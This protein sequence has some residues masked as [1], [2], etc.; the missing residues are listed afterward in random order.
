MD[1][2]P[3]LG[4]LNDAQREAVTAPV[5]PV[6]VLAGAGS[7]KTRVL[8]HRIAWVIQVEHASPHSVLAVTFTNKAAAEM[9]GRIEKLLGV[10]GSAMW[11]GTFHGIAHR[12]LRLHWR[13]AGLA[14]NFQI[15]DSEDQSRLIKK[16]MKAQELD[17]NRWSPREVQ[18]F[19]NANK[20]EGLRP[21][22]LKDNGD[23]TRR[24]FIKLYAD[25]EETCRKSGV[26]DF[27]ELLL[28]AYELWR[29][30]PSLLQHY[31]SRF[32]HV[33]VDEFQDTNNIQYNWMKLVAG[34]DGAPFVV[35][36]D[37]QSIYRW[38]GARVENLHQFSRD[39]PTAKLIRLEQNYRS[40]SSI[41]DAA[42]ALISNNTGR[43]GKNLWTSGSKGEP[44]KLYAAF[45]ERDE[46]DFI[47]QRI[48]D[49]SNTGGAR[50]D[51][52][53]LYRSNAQSR[54]FEEAFISSRIPYR[55][56]GGLRFFERAEI[57]DALAYLRI[58][59]SRLDD[60]SFERVINLPTRGIGAKSV[61]IIR[62]HAK[63][64]GSSLWEAAAACLS[65]DSLGPKAAT[66]V[67]GFMT[68]IERL[69]HEI[70]TLVLHE[71]VD[72]VLQAS[73]LI[74]HH[75]R[76]KSSGSGSGEGRVENLNELVSAARG[77]EPDGQQGEM[78]P[79]ESF[80]A[81]AVLESGEG[82]ADAW[83]DCVQMM[84]LHSAKGLEVPGGVPRRHGR[85]SL[86]APAFA[87]RHRRTRRRTS[88]LLR[89][90]DSRDEAALSHV[91]RAAPF[92]RYR[93]L[94]H[95]VALHQGSAGRAHRRSA[96]A[97]AGSPACRFRRPLP[98]ARRRACGSRRQTGCARKHSK[99]GEGVVL[100]VEGSGA[101]ARVEVR[102]EAVGTKVLMAQ[103]ANLEPV[104]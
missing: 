72:H 43:L 15:L 50:R 81:H 49:W 100:N 42:N 54:V 18:Q 82:Q 64:A 97:R 102:F 60:A 51:V 19:I 39:F 79:L 7:G 34:P 84:S 48:R 3:L 68:L 90:H 10:P 69:A 61:D 59:S 70:S 16:M 30:N 1:L 38:R 95:A 35:G 52:A 91:R 24:Q 6:L 78:P 104:R 26:V 96:P 11:I 12:L 58:T 23:P 13:E 55:V 37:D 98:V 77:F 41:L 99:F 28:R 56:Y 89:R 29:D 67:R 33:L 46:A 22:K 32:R 44:I 36:D 75:K 8:T 83:E 9:R 57:K 25:Y 45:N 5:G 87:E 53:I 94:R 47:V 71:Q 14:Q 85:R 74:E 20:D 103:Y 92:A 2:T 93:Q 27:A 17:E 21:D 73:G 65:D 88:S 76:D 63:G 101:H 4:P 86:P 31:R 66:A 80:L 62:E 40:T